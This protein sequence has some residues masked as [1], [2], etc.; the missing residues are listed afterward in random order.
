MDKVTEAT[1]VSRE[2]CWRFFQ[3]I[4]SYV[5]PPS[6]SHKF[7][8]N[9]AQPLCCIRPGEIAWNVRVFKSRSFILQNI[10]ALSTIT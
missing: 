6:D 9:T 10:V 7:S 5:S 2:N 4:S 8:E 1:C 3:I